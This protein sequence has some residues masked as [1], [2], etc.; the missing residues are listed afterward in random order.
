MAM[1][2]CGDGPGS[3]RLV[4][5]FSQIGAES[6]W[7]T[8]ETR[9]IQVEAEKRGIDLRFNDAQQRQENQIRALRGFIAQGVDYIV[10]APVVATGCCRFAPY[11][12]LIFPQGFRG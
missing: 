11:R 2:G 4:V 5:G 9:S 7:R 1:T 6:A 10:L 3:D 8:A 12:R